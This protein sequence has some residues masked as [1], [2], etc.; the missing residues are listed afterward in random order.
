MF[1][2]FN[3]TQKER[4]AIGILTA[5]ALM[6]FLNLGFLDLQAW[7]EA[8]YAVRAEG[9]LR[10]GGWL[11]QTPFAIDGLYSSLHPPLY[12]WL[13]TV[14]FT[15][16]GVTEF[17]ARFFSAVLGGLTLIVI[18]RM[19]KR[20]GDAHVGFIAALLFGLN[21]FVTFFSRQ[22]QFD[23]AL[24][25][26]LSL[27]VLLLLDPSADRSFRNALFAGVCVG[28]ALM[29]K[30]Y[31]GLGIPLVCFLWIV[32]RQSDRK[33]SAELVEQTAR[34]TFAWYDI[35]RKKKLWSALGIL[36]VAVLVV[37]AP[38]H[39]YMTIEH[40]KGDPL[41]FIKSSALFERTIYGVEGNIKPLEVL[42]F[43]NQ[44]FVLFPFGVA[45]FGHGLYRVLREKRRDWELLG[46]WFLLF[47]LVFSVMRTKLAVYMLPML[48]PASLIA[49]R[50]IVKVT[51]GVY[52]R[53]GAAVFV[54]GTLFS[55]LWASSQEWRNATKL[56]ISR[57]FHLQPPS[58]AETLTILPFFVLACC[59]I[60]MWYLS[61]KK[62]WIEY[63]RPAIPYLL[64]IPSFMVCYYDIIGYDRFQYKDGAAELVECIVERQPSEIIVA[65][66]ERNPQLSYYLEGAD[67]GWRDDLPVR[68]IVPPKDRTQFRSWLTDEVSGIP[69]AALV[70]IEKDKF[71]RYEWVTANEV[72]PPDYALVFESRR[73]AAFQRMPAI[74][75]ARLNSAMIP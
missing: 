58:S 39:V 75:V 67:I 50:E 55:V 54:A 24:V 21:P 59:V 73:Y 7:D 42:Y 68:R 25:F 52:S 32:S 66:Y 46:M 1:E 43:I 45:W 2:R 3:D 8:L 72:I 64:F 16:L 41:F 17:A 22:G 74:Q 34:P 18:Y 19:G 37:A 63:L 20:L 49:A 62:G 11:D 47:F 4:L 65:G 6:R 35:D 29:T 40:G 56:L 13:T 27:A 48:V 26:F 70:V 12:I 60:G 69:D 10:F 23:A 36:L 44:L 5:V 31:V 28:A 51:R 57:L 15:F 61:I 38:W 71:I 53:K 33:K 9:I 14:S 30:L